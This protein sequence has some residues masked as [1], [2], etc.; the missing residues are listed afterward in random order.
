MKTKPISLTLFLLILTGCASTPPEIA[1]QEVQNTVH[2]RSGFIS[3][4]VQ[5]S[6]QQQH[7][8]NQ[9]NEGLSTVLTQEAALQIALCNAPS[10]QAHY[11]QLGVQTAEY[12]QAIRLNNPSLSLT[13]HSNALALE[14]MWQIVGLIMRPSRQTAASF[15]YTQQK[16]SQ[17]HALLNAIN[18]IRQRYIHA[19]TQAELHAMQ[20]TIHNNLSIANTL[21]QAQYQAGTVSA[22]DAAKQQLFTSSMYT[23]QLIAKNNADAARAELAL[24][25]GLNPTQSAQLNLPTRLTMPPSLTLDI[26]QLE[27][28]AWKNRLDVKALQDALQQEA[29][30]AKMAVPQALLD[31]IQIGAEYDKTANESSTSAK[32]ELTLPLFNQGQDTQQ[33]ANARL[34]EL[35]Y[36]LHAKRQQIHQ[37]IQSNYR[38]LQLNHTLLKQQRDSILPL[39]KQILEETKRYYNGMLEGIYTLLE[40]QREQVEAG[41]QLI[42]AE[43]NY[44]LAYYQLEQSVSIP[45]YSIAITHTPLT[46]S[47]S[48]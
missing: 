14:A 13:S 46:S 31:G 4:F 25:L 1:V 37:E 39:H 32:L 10:I 21:T 20:T 33:A 26:A 18:Q 19:V 36:L 48:K 35:A 34:Q 12:N 6:A 8:Q 3:P 38:A 5:N 29:Q 42:Q 30:R 22:R 47:T 11:A 24:A 17:A 27:E 23:Q 45:L 44:C 15:I 28:T 41:K 9:V 7:C 40:T 43:Q 16:D 2:T